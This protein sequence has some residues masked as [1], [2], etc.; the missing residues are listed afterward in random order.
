MEE[1][2]DYVITVPCIEHCHKMPTLSSPHALRLEEGWP[3]P[4]L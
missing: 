3:S 2:R 1:K 4:A